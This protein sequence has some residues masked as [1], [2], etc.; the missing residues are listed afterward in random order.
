MINKVFKSQIG[1]ML[2]VYMDDMIVKTKTDVDH[3]ADLAEIF[4]EVRK[5][6]MRHNPEKCT[7]GMRVGKFL[8]FYLTERGIE[9]NPNT[10]RAATKIRARKLK[11][12][13]LKHQNDCRPV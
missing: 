5:H 2:E 11:K 4:G 7:F 3:I 8:G 9:A 1:R 6:N 12:E 10:F 13:V